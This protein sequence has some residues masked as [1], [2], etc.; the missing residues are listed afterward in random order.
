MQREQ[1]AR[2][3]I[4]IHSLIADNCTISAKLRC[5]M[6]G[7][8]AT[9]R[10]CYFR[11][12]LNFFQPL[13]GELVHFDE[14]LHSTRNK[15]IFRKENSEK[16]QKE[17]RAREQTE[18]ISCFRYKMFN[19]SRNCISFWG[20]RRNNMYTPDAMFKSKKISET[21]VFAG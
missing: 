8:T 21:G 20:E 13:R 11:C 15:S 14:N 3:S 7:S 1:F 17:Q 16:V 9:G 12:L 6:Q 2:A 18:K 4:A 10:R 5:T 19:N